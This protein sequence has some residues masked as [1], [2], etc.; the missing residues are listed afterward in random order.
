MKFHRIDW[1]NG[2]EKRAFR[3]IAQQIFG[4]LF[5]LYVKIMRWGDSIQHSRMRANKYGNIIKSLVVYRQ[6]TQ[7]YRQGPFNAIPCIKYY[8]MFRPKTPFSF[9]I[10]IGKMHMLH[11]ANKWACTKPIIAMC[12]KHDTNRSY[13]AENQTIKIQNHGVSWMQNSY[14]TQFFSFQIT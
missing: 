13:R 8:L 7:N 10:W 2:K 6:S 1:C 4:H 3:A 5:H 12:T 9:R 14:W 11:I